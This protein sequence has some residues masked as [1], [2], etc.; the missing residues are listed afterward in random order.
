M[1]ARS[2]GHASIGPVTP[3]EKRWNWRTWNLLLQ[4][5]EATDGQ[6]TRQ[7]HGDMTERN[8]L[9]AHTSALRAIQRR[10]WVKCVGHGDLFD[11][12][13]GEERTMPAWVVTAAGRGA[14]KAARRARLTIQ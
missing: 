4:I 5:Q 2:H 9:V 6:D 10:G 8:L 14:L 13:S 12:R 11:D 3:K 7:L 1:S